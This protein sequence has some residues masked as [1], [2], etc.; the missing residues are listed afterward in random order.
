MV[1]RV[2]GFVAFLFAVA[3]AAPARAEGPRP[4]DQ[5][6][7]VTSTG[8]LVVDGG[9]VM[10]LPATWQTGLSTG[11]GGGVSYGRTFALGLRGSW[12]TSSESSIAW[13]V[14][15]DDVRLR[16]TGGVGRVLGRGG[17]AFRLGLGTTL[18]YEDRVR[19][20]GTRAGLTGSDLET[21]TLV[22]MPAGELEGV[23]GVHVGGPWLLLLSGGPSVLV[24]DGAWHAGWT[25]Q[26]G[27][28]WQP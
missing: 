23:V 20:Q 16:L 6:A 18:V 19:N 28:G 1:F 7:K 21:S 13:A 8:P 17:V 3:L 25:T 9:L 5:L 27:V 26:L 22:A 12:S 10:G 15:H 11:L 2:R 14:R 24:T 4:V